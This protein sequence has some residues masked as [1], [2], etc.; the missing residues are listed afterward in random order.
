MNVVEGCLTSRCYMGSAEGV[1]EIL[2]SH[3]YR[4]TIET[5]N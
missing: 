1:G 5:T 4:P 2:Q 3:W